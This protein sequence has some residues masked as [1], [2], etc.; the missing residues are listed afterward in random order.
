[1]SRAGSVL[2]AGIAGLLCLSACDGI[3]TSPEELAAQ[4]SA[5]TFTVLQNGTTSNVLAS[6]GSLVITLAA[7]GTTTG[8]LSIPASVNGGTPLNASMAG[9]FTL[10]TGIVDF[11]QSADTFVR[12][13]PFTVSKKTLS[14][15]RTFSGATVDVVL[16]RQ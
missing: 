7:D 8:Q 5:T 14:G 13:M 6:G 10:A 9:T 16:T 15:N 12:D 11:H 4:Y 1:M 2:Q 3:P